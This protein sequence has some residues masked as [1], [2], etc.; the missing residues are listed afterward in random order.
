MREKWRDEYK[1]DIVEQKQTE[2]D[3]GKLQYGS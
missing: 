2:H 3:A 1:E